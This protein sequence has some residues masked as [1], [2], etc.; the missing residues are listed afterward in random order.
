MNREIT[1]IVMDELGIKPVTEKAFK[2]PCIWT[3]QKNDIVILQV[4]TGK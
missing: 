3:L 1:P 4:F 2:V